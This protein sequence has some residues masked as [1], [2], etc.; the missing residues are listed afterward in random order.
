V[1]AEGPPGERCLGESSEGFVRQIWMGLLRNVSLFNGG[2]ADGLWYE[3]LYYA[4]CSS[5]GVRLG[6]VVWTRNPDNQTLA[7]LHL[8]GRAP[9]LDDY[10]IPLVMAPE[11]TLIAY[12]YV[13]ESYFETDII[14]NLH[15]VFAGNGLTGSSYNLTLRFLVDSTSWTAWLSIEDWA[16]PCLR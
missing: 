9:N 1:A 5:N 3:V 7:S 10:V 16:N 14:L 13:N 2:F 15:P 4:G 8:Y 12:R 11:R 6:D